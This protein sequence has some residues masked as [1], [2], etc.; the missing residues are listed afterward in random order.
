MGLRVHTAKAYA[1]TFSLEGPRDEVLAVCAQILDM[2]PRDRREPLKP[3]N[4][5]NHR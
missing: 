5:W 3:A 4:A 1:P 2:P